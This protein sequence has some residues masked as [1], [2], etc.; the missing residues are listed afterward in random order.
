MLSVS[1]LLYCLMTFAVTTDV[2]YQYWYLF[3]IHTSTYFFTDQRHFL[4]KLWWIYYLLLSGFADHWFMSGYCIILSYLFQLQRICFYCGIVN[5]TVFRKTLDGKR[6]IVYDPLLS[7]NLFYC[8]VFTIRKSACIL[9][10]YNDLVF[11]VIYNSCI[12]LQ[13]FSEVTGVSSVVE[14]LFCS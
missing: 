2:F 1:W 7:C 9:P 10:L 3:H 14:K 8:Y 11:V 12:L 6:T 5:C 4:M 13:M